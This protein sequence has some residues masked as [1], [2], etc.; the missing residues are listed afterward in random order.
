MPRPVVRPRCGSHR[1]QVTGGNE[2]KV[3]EIVIHWRAAR[4]PCTARCRGSGD[5]RAVGGWV[6]ADGCEAVT[7]YAGQFVHDGSTIDDVS[8]T[9]SSVNGK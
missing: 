6:A 7:S 4:C 2:L 9:I 5:A 8:G 1:L 3:R